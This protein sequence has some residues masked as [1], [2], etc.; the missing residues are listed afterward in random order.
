MEDPRTG[1]QMDFT[2]ET[3]DEVMREEVLQKLNRFLV[4][5]SNKVWIDSTQSDAPTSP[6][7]NGDSPR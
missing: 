5:K 4:N 3:E 2:T 7:Q 6:F 1:K